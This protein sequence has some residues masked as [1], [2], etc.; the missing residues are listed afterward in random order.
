MAEACE[1][2]GAEA[3]AGTADKIVLVRP[4]RSPDGTWFSRFVMPDDGRPLH[5]RCAAHHRE[6]PEEAGPEYLAWEQEQLSAR[7]VAR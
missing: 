1:V 6:V 2:C 7:G 3:V 4:V 5:W